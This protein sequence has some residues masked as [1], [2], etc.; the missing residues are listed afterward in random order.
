MDRDQR[1]LFQAAE[2]Q[3]AGTKTYSLTHLTKKMTHLVFAVPSEHAFYGQRSQQL[4][5]HPPA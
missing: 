5:S 4:C 1:Q 2:F 3:L